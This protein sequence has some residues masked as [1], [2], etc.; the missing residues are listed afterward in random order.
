V[1]FDSRSL[2][3]PVNGIQ[4]E[5]IQTEIY[6]R[7][8]TPTTAF[9]PPNCVDGGIHSENVIGYGSFDPAQTPLIPV[10]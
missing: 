4:K 8:A 7:A 1:H 9:L 6:G 10:Y 5:V 3:L 2:P